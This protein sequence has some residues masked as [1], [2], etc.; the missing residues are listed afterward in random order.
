LRQT[1]QQLTATRLGITSFEAFAAARDKP[2]SFPEWGLKKYP[3]G[4]DPSY[5]NEMG[6]IFDRRNMAFETY[7]NV[8]L[9][10]RPYLAL[11]TQAPRALAAFKKWFGNGLLESRFAQR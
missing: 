2:M 10:I 1:F 11:G 4:D 6:A 7:F 3:N 8:N 5:I 9:K